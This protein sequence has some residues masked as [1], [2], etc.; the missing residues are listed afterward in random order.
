[1]DGDR[2]DFEL[3][4]EGGQLIRSMIIDGATLLQLK[5]CLIILN[6]DIID[7]ILPKYWLWTIVELK[8]LVLHVIAI[9][10]LMI[11]VVVLPWTAPRSISISSTM[12][13]VF[14]ATKIMASAT[15]SRTWTIQIDAHIVADGQM[16]RAR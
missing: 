9:I 4:I 16:T 13:P 15:S 6:I 11:V 1:M 2:I 5:S 7:I 8:L 14:I 10:V 12:I 3:S